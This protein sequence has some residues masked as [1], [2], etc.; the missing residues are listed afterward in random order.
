M[1]RFTRFFSGKFQN[2]GNCAGVKKLTNIMSGCCYITYQ[3][4]C[5][6]AKIQQHVQAR[7][8]QSQ[9]CRSFSRLKWPESVYHHHQCHH[10][11]LREQFQ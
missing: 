5:V 1:S 9:T 3:A 11:H 10:H 7:E 6:H 2:L 8:Q 4:W